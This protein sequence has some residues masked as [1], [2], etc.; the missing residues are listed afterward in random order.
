MGKNNTITLT[1]QVRYFLVDTGI[2]LLY[3]VI[4]EPED[5]TILR[6]VKQ[7][8]HSKL[9]SEFIELSQWILMTVLVTA[10][11]VQVISSCCN[12]CKT[13]YVKSKSVRVQRL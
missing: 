2:L 6:K 11:I 12:N 4:P 3:L 5:L 10:F 1:L 7:I 13:N 8:L 9:N